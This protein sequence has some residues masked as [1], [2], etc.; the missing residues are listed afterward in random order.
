MWYVIFDALLVWLEDV[1]GDIFHDHPFVLL[2]NG[3]E[4]L[5]NSSI[6][7]LQSDR[8]ASQC[9]ELHHFWD[10]H[11]QDVCLGVALHEKST[12]SKKVK[13]VYILHFVL[14]KRSPNQG[15][16]NREL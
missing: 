15:S 10:S 6:T 13:Q 9:H 12:T 7:N 2:W 4:N 3:W 1:I 5:H 8:S 11:G 14:V 16:S